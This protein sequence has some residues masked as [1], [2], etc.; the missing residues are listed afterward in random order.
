M[1]REPLLDL[2]QV[3][4]LEIDFLR[5]RAT[6]GGTPLRL[7]PLE[8]RL[9]RVLAAN[10]GRVLSRD[11]LLASVWPPG[12]YVSSR[13]VDSLIKRLRRKLPTEDGHPLIATVRGEG[14]RFHIS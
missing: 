10:P 5:R 7:T 3:G 1:T 13:S 11:D 4:G 2:I 9:I 6:L 14:Y 12:T 8:L